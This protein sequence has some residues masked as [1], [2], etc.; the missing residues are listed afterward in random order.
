MKPI[1][2]DV[3]SDDWTLDP[4][5]LDHAIG[6][7]GATIVMLVAPFGMRRTFA[8]Q[9]EICQRRT[10]AVVIDSAAGLGA[11]RPDRSGAG[12]VFEVFSMHATKPFGVGEGGAVFGPSNKEAALRAAVSFALTSHDRPDGPAWGFNGKMSELHAAVGLAQLDRF[13]ACVSA[14]QAF[15]GRYISSLA[16]YSALDFPRD[17][18]DAPWQFF[19][20]LMPNESVAEQFIQ[21]AAARSIEIRRYYRPSLSRWPNANLYGDCP[22]AEDLARRMCAL[23]VRSATFAADIDAIVDP[24]TD[25]LQSALRDSDLNDSVRG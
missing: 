10:V 22:I 16:K 14:R 9:L 15:V 4:E 7:T 20:L 6:A 3:T 17:V 5:R 23:P 21:N 19:P 11:P 13:R 12:D 18:R 1:V 2:M 25:A 8:A 24:T